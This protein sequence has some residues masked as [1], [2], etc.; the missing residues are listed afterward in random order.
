MSAPESYLSATPQCFLA[1]APRGAGLL[2]ALVYY[3]AGKDV[4]GWWTGSRDYESPTAY[5]KLENFYSLENTVF[6]AT[7]GSDIYGGWRY[8]YSKSEP[9]LDD[10]IM[11]EDDIAHNLDQLQEAFARE[12]LWFSGD[13]ESSSEQKAFASAELAVQNAN[14]QYRRLNKLEKDQAIW[15]F[16]SHDFDA[17]VLDYISPRWPLDYGKELR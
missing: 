16:R 14:I 10:P 12:W 4:Y 5:F 3:V 11:V 13:P 8:Q 2:C 1:Y 6:N 15:T 17:A 9:K 7:E